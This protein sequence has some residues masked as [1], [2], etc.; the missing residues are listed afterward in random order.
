MSFG[1]KK[2]TN[3]YDSYFAKGMEIPD[4]ASATCTT[5]LSAGKTG[6]AL[7]A[8]I[9][10]ATAVSIPAGKKVTFTPV[11]CADEAG[12]Y[13]APNPAYGITLTNSGA[14]ALTYA[15][16]DELC[17]FVL[18][19]SEKEYVNITITTDGEITGTIDVAQG[20]TPR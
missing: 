9:T 1:Y 7:T 10:A 3:W 12:T 15:A 18:P 5:P 11:Y 13:A 14:S 19:D 8:S 20:Y 6:N 16:G 2:I 17:S 4:S